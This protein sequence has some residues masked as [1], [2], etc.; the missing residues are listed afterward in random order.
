MT[1]QPTPPIIPLSELEDGQEAD[2]FVML[3]EKETHKTR[4][5]KP[6]IKV[7][8]RDVRREVRFPVWSD[9][10]IY[11]DC[12]DNWKV[13]MFYK[14]RALYR[15]SSF[16]PQLDIRRIRLAVDAD[17]KDGFD[18]LQCRETSPFPSEAMYEE[19]LALAAGNIGKGKLL[20][21]V[22]RIFKDNRQALLESAAARHNH[23]AYYG[24]LL[25]HTLSVAKI[26]VA[27]C[28]HYDTATPKR[29]GTISRPLVVAGAILHD[30]GK[31]REMRTES[32]Y[33]YHTTE[34]AL[35]GHVVIG[36][37]YV[38]DY[39]VAVELEPEIR[40]RLEHIIL[41]HQGR[42]EWGSPKPPMSMEAVIVHHA[43]AVDAL[44]GVH[45]NI[46]KA[47]D[48][49]GEITSRKNIL[50]HGILKTP[51]PKATDAKSPAPKE[52]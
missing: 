31:L 7:M 46:R 2:V 47:D 6:Y 52:R 26:A 48:T 51:T 45:E 36:R 29:K 37:D 1:K 25:E 49:P 5:G 9:L 35:I 34:G 50:G 20:N 32:A 21:L 43:D 18:P 27:L 17:R 15:V 44:L 10:P 24:G 39:A 19:L 40:I 12:R 8:F 4:D 33:T 3:A 42:P 41:A 13:G 16:G 22:T 23:H 30:I 14:L 11:E 38:R 28:D